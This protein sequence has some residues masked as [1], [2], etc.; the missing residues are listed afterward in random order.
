[1]Q[2]E[3]LRPK[4]GGREETRSHCPR[5]GGTGNVWAAIPGSV[6]KAK[7]SKWRGHHRCEPQWRPWTGNWKHLGP[8]RLLGWFN[9]ELMRGGCPSSQSRHTCFREK[10]PD[11]GV[12]YLAALVGIGLNDYCFTCNLFILKAKGQIHTG[13][14]KGL[15]INMQTNAS[16]RCQKNI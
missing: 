9:S 12:L 10:L 7:V 16:A 8:V 4:G 5:V 15:F 11:L 3:C 2:V 13:W 1:M 6:H 14:N